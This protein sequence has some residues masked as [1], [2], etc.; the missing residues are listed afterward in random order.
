MRKI[1][2]F[3]ITFAILFAS[4]IISFCIPDSLF[5]K[6]ITESK[7]YIE[8]Y[9]EYNW[10][11]AFTERDIVLDNTD[12]DMLDLAIYD[13]TLGEIGPIR[14]ACYINGYTRFWHGYIVV[15]RLLLVFLNYTEIRYYNMLFLFLILGIDLI[16]MSKKLDT[17][18]AIAFL[19]AMCMGRFFISAYCFSYM[20]SFAIALS[21]IWYILVKWMKLSESKLCSIFMLIGM[22]ENFFD[23]LTTPLLTWGLPLTIVILLYLKSNKLSVAEVWKR[24]ISQS[25]FW[26]LGYAGMWFMKWFLGTIILHVNVFADAI[27]SIFFRTQGNESYPVDYLDML[28]KNI[29]RI[30]FPNVPWAIF[31]AVLILLWFLFVIVLAKGHGDIRKMTLFIFLTLCP[32][33]WYIVLVN[34]SQIHAIFTYKLQIISLFSY[35][36]SFFYCIDGKS[37]ILVKRRRE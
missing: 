25:V 22:F 26:V 23:F 15:L 1:F 36:S 12:F 20:V 13:G 14:K 28:S 33:V 11:V 8:Y 2:L 30:S 3:T 21:A 19:L 6:N 35:F 18:T 29:S 4:L 32:Y 27:T 7:K 34:H 17:R 24:I 16:L 5:Q 37:V 9:E 10:Y 31:I